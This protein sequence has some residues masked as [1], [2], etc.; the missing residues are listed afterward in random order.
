MRRQCD[1]NVVYYDDEGNDDFFEL[2]IKECA[3][4]ESFP[5][6]RRN[7]F[8]RAFSFLLYYVVAIPLVWFFER[9][10]LGVRFVNKKGIKKAG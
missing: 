1:K 8:Y 10:L 9:V 7:I 3:V 5:Y 4:D 6:V 2:G